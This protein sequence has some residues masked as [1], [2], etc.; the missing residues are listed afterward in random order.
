MIG[1]AELPELKRRSRSL[2]QH[3]VRPAFPAPYSTDVLLVDAEE[4]RKLCD[5]LVEKRP[6]MHEDEG[7]AAS[8]RDQVG[9]EDRLADPGRRDEDPDV[10]LKEDLRGLLLDRRE[11]ALE[12]NLQGLAP[13][14]LIAD[15]ERDAVLR[16]K[17]REIALAS[18]RQRDVLREL[19]GAGDH[20]WGGGCRESHHLLLVELR[21]LKGGETLD[22]VQA[23]SFSSSVIRARTSS[24]GVAI[25]PFKR[26]SPRPVSPESVLT[27]RP[28]FDVN[29]GDRANSRRTGT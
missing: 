26:G 22:P 17:S 25:G 24:F 6:T 15:D 8:L 27:S 20:P 10:F 9:A 1:G 29:P 21:V 14:T 13:V 4:H 7:A 16:E 18:S 23:R 11:R 19:F 3:A 2:V 28:I 5:P 12:S